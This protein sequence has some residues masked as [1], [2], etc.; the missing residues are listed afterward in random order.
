M[1]VAQS[2]TPRP[3]A[4]VPTEFKDRARDLRRR[5]MAVDSRIMPAFM[6]VT[7]PIAARLARHPRLRHDLIEDTIRAWRAQVP[8]EYRLGDV[9]IARGRHFELAIHEKRIS[10]HELHLPKWDVNEPGLG[11]LSVG[12]RVADGKLNAI[13]GTYGLA[14]LQA[15]ARRFERGT[16]DEASVLADQASAERCGWRGNTAEMTSGGSVLS[17]F[18]ARTWFAPS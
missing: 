5:V 9:V 17:V 10:A 3:F 16:R 15:L 7:A 8:A 18:S 13:R 6:A 11:V 12:F 2:S 1:I 4:P 14:N